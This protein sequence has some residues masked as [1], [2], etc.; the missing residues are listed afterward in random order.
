MSGLDADVEVQR[1]AF[2]LRVRFQT[3][4]VLAVMGP[5]GAGKT[6]L[7]RTLLGAHRPAW[8]RIR[9]GGRVL[10]DAVRG[11]DVPI[12]QRRIGYVPQGYRLF[13]HLSV[14]DNVAFGVPAPARQDRRARARRLLSRFDM[15]DLAARRPSGLSG[16]QQQRVAL[17][18]ALATEPDALLLDEP[19]AA[20]DAGA[21]PRVRDAVAR[22]LHATGLPTVVVTHEARDA[23]A[24]ARRLLVLEGGEVRQEGTFEE[25]GSVPRAAFVAAVAADLLGGGALPEPP[26]PDAV[27]EDE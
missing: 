8:G 4:G 25:V 3:S 16:G 10:Y 19:F 21:R 26:D 13:P 15:T 22:W 5:N 12:E 27:S 23:R 7:L 11:V 9:L 6:T 17:V 2:R 14:L 18:R 1:G 24:L 20:L